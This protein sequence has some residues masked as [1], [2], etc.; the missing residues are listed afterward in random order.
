MDI[1]KCVHC[2]HAGQFTTGP[3]H[4]RDDCKLG[5]WGATLS[6]LHHALMKV[7]AVTGQIAG[8]RDPGRPHRTRVSKYPGINIPT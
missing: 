2:V 1:N 3:R 5:G 7:I 4:I 6:V 8:S